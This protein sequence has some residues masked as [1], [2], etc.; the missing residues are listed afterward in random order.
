MYIPKSSNNPSYF[1][2]VV[3]RYVYEYTHKEGY[4]HKEAL[5]YLFFI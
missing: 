2:P 3:V 5:P 4:K 1:L